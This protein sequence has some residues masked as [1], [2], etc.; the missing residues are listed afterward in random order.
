VL[1]TSEQRISAAMNHKVDWSMMVVVAITAL[2]FGL[3]LI[4]LSRSDLTFDESASI[5]IARKPLAEMIPY[6]LSAF[7]EHPPVYYI[8]LSGWIQFA[9]QSE[10]ILRFLSVVMGTLSIPLMYRWVR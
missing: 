1:S 6:L 2:A 7:H 5:L 4:N 3:R 8:L 10:V 9:G